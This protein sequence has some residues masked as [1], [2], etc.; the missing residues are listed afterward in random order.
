[1]TPQEKK[2]WYKCL[3]KCPVRFQR[4]KAIGNYI[5]DFYCHKAKLVVEVDGRQH[6]SPEGQIYDSIRTERMEEFG[7]T[8]VRIPN[9]TIDRDFS[10]V[11]GYL[12]QTL[13]LSLDKNPEN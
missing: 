11:T 2:L 1:M 6:D 13:N 5:A 9:G 4:Q 7:L 8:V 10:Y 12:A 3:A